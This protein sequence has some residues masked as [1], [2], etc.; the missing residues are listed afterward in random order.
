MSIAYKAATHADV[1]LMTEMRIAFLED[2]LG[3]AEETEIEELRKNL[4]SYYAAAIS[5]DYLCEIAW[6][7]ER[8][9]AIGG[10]VIREQAGSFKNPSGRVAYVMN[11][12]TLPEYRR[13][14]I[15]SILLGRLMDRARGLGITAFELLATREGAPVYEKLGY[16]KHSE[17]LYRKME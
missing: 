15:G 3:K 11:M 6:D 2:I 17:P 16:H 10:I 7:R 4:S 9:A 14:G 5:N 1:P 12:Y 8:A 13:R